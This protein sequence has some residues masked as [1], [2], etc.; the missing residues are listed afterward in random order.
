MNNT[1]KKLTPR[2][3]YNTAR[4]NLILMVVLTAFNVILAATGSHS[5]MLF[6]ATVPYLFAMLG[7][8]EGM[9]ELL[10]PGI[11]LALLGTVVYLV[12]WIL[13]KKHYAWMIVALVLFSIDTLIM[14]GMYVLAGDF[15]G[16]IDV[17]IHI[18]VM[19]YLIAGVV[20][21]VKLKNLPEEEA[22]E[23]LEVEFTAP[24]AYNPA[25][26]GTDTPILRVADTEVKARV[27]AEIDA[28]G[29]NICYRRVKHTNEL[30]IDGYVY[31]DLEGVMEFTH[32]LSARVGGK[33]IEAGFDG[34]VKS[35]IKINGE[36]IL[37][38]T[39]LW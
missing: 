10:V 2:T 32:V 3:K 30:V 36:I 24:P 27:L 9:S 13:S 8:F 19:Y 38:K 39:R 16:V 20:N 35:Y 23:A 29:H 33:L 14:I 6:S 26:D 12:C 5:M 21:G 11:V 15:S 7:T 22:E 31:A 37:K 17:L 4:S 34:G 28:E 25:V 18:W 1:Q